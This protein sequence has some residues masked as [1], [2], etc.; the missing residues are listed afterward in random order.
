MGKAVK[1][2][3]TRRDSI[4]APRVVN[5]VEFTQT[6]ILEAPLERPDNAERLIRFID[7]QAALIRGSREFPDHFVMGA[8]EYTLNAIR[9]TITNKRTGEDYVMHVP[10]ITCYESESLARYAE[11][12]IKL[13]AAYM[14]ITSPKNQ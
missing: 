13:M 12:S 2:K 6:H 10:C 8:P 5:A 3:N 9:V 7:I 14:N 4:L 11:A 1:K